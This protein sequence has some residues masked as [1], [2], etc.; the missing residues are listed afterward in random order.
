MMADLQSIPPQHPAHQTS[1]RNPAAVYLASLSTGSR[2]TLRQALTVVG[3]MLTGSP[4]NPIAVPWWDLRYQHTQA[5]RSKLAEDYAPATANKML[6]ALRGVL[7]ESWRLGYLDAET[8]HRAVDLKSVKAR[9]L[10]A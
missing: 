9:P 5:V 3:E 2:R 6:S 1:E 10:G 7:R 8:F 4:V